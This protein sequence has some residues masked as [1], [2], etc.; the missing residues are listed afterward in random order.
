MH[1]QQG[2]AGLASDQL[3]EGPHADAERVGGQLDVTR[4][5]ERLIHVP[6]GTGAAVQHVGAVAAGE[7][8][9]GQVHVHGGDVGVRANAQVRAFARGVQ[10]DGRAV[11]PHAHFTADESGER[12]DEQ[13]PA[14]VVHLVQHVGDDDAVRGDRAA[15]GVTALLVG[16]ACPRRDADLVDSL[17]ED[18]EIV[19]LE[20]AC[21]VA[22]VEVGVEHQEVRGRA[23]DSVAA[24]PRRWARA[25][26]PLA[27]ARPRC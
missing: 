8:A 1:H 4:R 6:E 27:A 13:L 17:V 7:A 3:V 11:A 5:G 10:G 21:V 23:R 25:A 9:R 20:R 19:A 18:R 24:W 22:Q 12:R 16:Q 26:T 15:L 2:A 14:R